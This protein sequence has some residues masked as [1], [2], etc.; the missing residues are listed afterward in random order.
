L[1]KR[2]GKEERVSACCVA[3]KD[4]K[5]ARSNIL[6]KKVKYIYIIVEDKE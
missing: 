1:R 5:Y 6:Q 4:T 3:N 2:K